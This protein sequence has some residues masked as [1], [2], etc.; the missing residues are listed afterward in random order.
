M[1]NILFLCPHCSSPVEAPED[2]AGETAECPECSREIVVPD[3]PP[4]T[5]PRAKRQV[6]LRPPVSKQASKEWQGE[7]W[8]KLMQLLER[9]SNDIHEIRNCLA[10]CIVLSI[11]FAIL[12]SVI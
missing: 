3:G 5:S 12:A 11:L 4:P 1:P 6:F 8:T 9:Q 7:Q 10:F 2:V